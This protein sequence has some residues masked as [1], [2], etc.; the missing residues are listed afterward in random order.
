MN[1]QHF[2]SLNTG[3]R[4]H[5]KNWDQLPIDDFVIDKVKELATK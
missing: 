5:S 4:I 2:M 3:K 1:G